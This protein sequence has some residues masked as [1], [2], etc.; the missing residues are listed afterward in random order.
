MVLPVTKILLTRSHISRSALL[1]TVAWYAKKGQTFDLRG[2]ASGWM[3]GRRQARSSMRIFVGSQKQET[4]AGL[5]QAEP[6]NL[7]HTL[8]TSFLVW[9][10]TNQVYARLT[11]S[12]HLGP[13]HI[14]THF[15]EGTCETHRSKRQEVSSRSEERE[16]PPSNAIN[17]PHVRARTWRRRQPTQHKPQ[18]EALSHQEPFFR[19]D[20]KRILLS[21][22]QK[23]PWMR[24][25]SEN[26]EKM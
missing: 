18:L 17:N 23:S 15:A 16:T 11:Y 7:S 9:S 4:V 20:S 25:I 13:C 3:R 2:H 22:S 21:A 6:R 26:S 10:G 19:L 24:R 1:V 12:W 8:K 5:F 14:E